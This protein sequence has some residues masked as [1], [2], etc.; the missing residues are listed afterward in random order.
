MF[1]IIKKVRL[2]EKKEFI[3]IALNLNHIVFLIYITTI[4][5]CFDTS[6]KI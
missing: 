4:N 6:D 1:L 2:I 5:I 3:A